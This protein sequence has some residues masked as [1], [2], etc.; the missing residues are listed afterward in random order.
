MSFG[1]L[2]IELPSNY[3]GGE[4]IAYDE[5]NMT[6]I[7]TQTDF[8]RKERL[9][10][11]ALC[12]TAL[13]TDI[14]FEIDTLESGH[15]LIVVYS[16]DWS[17]DDCNIMSANKNGGEQQQPRSLEGALSEALNYFSKEA[18]P[19]AIMLREDYEGEMIE[20]MGVLAFK[21]MIRFYN[22]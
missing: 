5:V 17:L 10:E 15:R 8:R 1:T 12:V 7:N 14:D 22:S 13:S 4:I 6:R 11:F 16:L 9:N 19:I 21:S 3:T 2:L 18:F 20:K